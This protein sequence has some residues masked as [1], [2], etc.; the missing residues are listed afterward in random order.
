MLVA[1]HYSS[2]STYY[3]L[4]TVFQHGVL[5]QADS[6]FAKRLCVTEKNPDAEQIQHRG[7]F[8]RYKNDGSSNGFRHNPQGR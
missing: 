2:Y 3:Y 1:R 8:W 5:D 6:I 7:F 4:R